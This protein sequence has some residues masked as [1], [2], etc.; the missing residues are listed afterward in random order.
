MAF[1]QSKKRKPVKLKQKTK[2]F[3]FFNCG[4]QYVCTVTYPVDIADY[5]VKEAFDRAF[6][7]KRDKTIIHNKSAF[8]GLSQYIE[9]EI[10]T[11]RE[12]TEC[13]MQK[14]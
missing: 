10:K 13:Q 5:R 12:A 7:G 2:S 6:V 4:E 9:Y 11:V 14:S 3:R 8:A 1:K